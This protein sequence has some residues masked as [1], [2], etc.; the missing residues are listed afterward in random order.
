[1]SA[2]LYPNL[3]SKAAYKRAI[4]AGKKITAYENL[5]FGQEK[6]TNGEAV[7]EGPHYPKAHRFYEKATIQDSLVVKIS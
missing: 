4:A 7:F 3:P 2:Y 5:P 6:L 1:M